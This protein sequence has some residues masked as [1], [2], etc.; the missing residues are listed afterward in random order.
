MLIRSKYFCSCASGGRFVFLYVGAFLYEC[1]MMCICMIVFGVFV[2]LYVCPLGYVCM[3]ASSG[4]SLYV[5]PLMYFCM[6]VR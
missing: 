4:V 1:P 6:F 3:F 5:C 2:L